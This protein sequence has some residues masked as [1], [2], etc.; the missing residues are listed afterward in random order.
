MVGA[1][2]PRVMNQFE[3][4]K[5]DFMMLLV[6]GEWSIIKMMTIKEANLLKREVQIEALLLFC[7]YGDMQ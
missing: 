7:N 6:R 2:L 3:N 1:I 4:W 5:D